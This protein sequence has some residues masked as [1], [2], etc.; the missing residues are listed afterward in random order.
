MQTGLWQQTRKTNKEMDVHLT[1]LALLESSFC[2]CYDPRSTHCS[3]LFET[4]SE[5]CRHG[6]I[7]FAERNIRESA[8]NPFEAA[9]KSSL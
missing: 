4:K 3:S 6:P 1:E 8:L 5:S 7:L 9:A 2:E